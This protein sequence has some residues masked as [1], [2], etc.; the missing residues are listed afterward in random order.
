MNK[1]VLIL[2][3]LLLGS[4]YTPLMAQS[5]SVT[6]R[7][8][9][10][11]TGEELIG[12]NV[13]LRGTTYGAS[14]DI[15]GY[16]TI[17][18][19]RPGEYDIEFSYIGYERQL[20]TGVRVSAG[21][22]LE[23]SVELNEQVLTTEDEIVIVGARPIFDIEESSTTSRVSRDAIQAA[24][25]RRIDEIVGQQAGVVRDPTG[26]YIRGGRASEAAF[27][28]DGVSAQDPLA[29][30]GLG[31]DLGAGAYAEV[32]VTTGG[33]GAEIGDATSGVV[34]VRTQEGGQDYSGYFS[35]KRDNP[36]RMTASSHNFFTDVYEVNLGGPVQWYQSLLPSLGINTPGTMT[37]FVAGQVHLTNEFYKETADQIQSSLIDNTFWSPRQDNRWSGMGKLTWRIR[38]SMRFEASYQRSLTINQNTRML[39]IVGDD[40][41]IRPGYQFFYSLNLDNANTYAHDSKVAY[42]KWTHT[43]SPAMFY[44]VQI[45]R[46]FTRLRTDVNG[47]HWRP[48]V[49]EGE[50]DGE[51]IV[52]PPTEIF[53]TG[54]DFL[55]VLPGPGLVNNGGYAPLWHDHYAEEYTIRA[56]MTRYFFNRNNRLHAGFELKFNDYQ[57]IDIQRPWVGAPIQ[58]DEDTFTET[59]FLGASSDIWNVKPRRGAL[60][61]TDQI[62]YQGLIANLGLRLEYWFPGSYVDDMV[63]DPDS[64]I[65]DEIREAYYNDT[66]SLFGHRFKMRLLPR[67]NVSFP[68][69]E[70]QVLYFNYGHKTKLPHPSHVYAGLDPRY[71][72]AS[73]LSNLG[74]PN[75][76]PEVDISYEI[77]LR[78]QIT[79]NDAL[80]I[81]AFWSDKYDFVTSERLII[82]DSQG[83][84]V[85]RNFRVN[86][87]FARVRGVEVTY[88]KRHRD[89]FMGN[90]SVTYSRAEGLSSTSN[91]ALRNI[92]AGDQFGFNVETPLAWDRP[93]DVKANVTFT[94]DRQQ[95]LLGLAPLNQ[96][97]LYLSGN[98]RSGMRYTPYEFVDFQRHPVTGERNWRP[99]YE[100][101]N[102]PAMRFSEIGPSWL[103]FDL[104]FQRWFTVAD[105]RFIVFL[106]IT[107]LLN[108]KNPAI[109]NPV[110]GEGYKT[111]YPT[112]PSEL[113]GLRDDRSYDVP[114]N[115]RDERYVDPRDNN[116]PSY[117]NP[118]N[119]LQQRHIMFG[120]AFNF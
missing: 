78:N 66:Y 48:T 16:Y 68:V 104:N 101:D 45:S 31:L 8:T 36:G 77:G 46:M 90:V 7:V 25:V 73:R 54:R 120:F 34:S 70:N 40:V 103:M 23:L 5:G 64:W 51:S 74:N 96:M 55:Y 9:D 21:E 91:D 85:Q 100:R 41:Q 11:D 35:H 111:S 32:E 49:V 58:I 43:V 86:G 93:W 42:V 60:F 76:D 113:I 116:S 27:I 1:N 37:F 61:L 82:T 26:M 94:Y 10:A 13:F 2:T 114:I 115:V 80:N 24:P 17:S 102:D 19:I 57:W 108:A 38:P 39:Q 105:T 92:L 44:D 52:M 84:D 106:E 15:N 87:D 79:S 22:Q 20:Y 4:V 14:S 63:D 98:F 95:P 53:E 97:K 72:D 88:I 18:G 69:R 110:T 33:V 109:I 112:S 28:V 119:Y 107:N 30:T 117:L 56:T 81:S 75:L 118:A 12:V 47:R 29:G 83:R 62:R 89:W 59:Q 99:I 50:F 71:Q 67:I 3:L 6:G 65:A